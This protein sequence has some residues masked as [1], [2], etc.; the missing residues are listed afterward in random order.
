MRYWQFTMISISTSNCKL[1]HLETLQ[2]QR[3]ICHGACHYVATTSHL[4]NEQHWFLAECDPGNDFENIIR[5]QQ[6]ATQQLGGFCRCC[7]ALKG[8][9]NCTI[10]MLSLTGG[11]TS[12]I[13]LKLY[14]ASA[15]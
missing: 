12:R 7:H 9:R 15:I 13:L 3:S 2:A 11:L 14:R 8:M 6:L 5:A 1:H 10:R 4:G